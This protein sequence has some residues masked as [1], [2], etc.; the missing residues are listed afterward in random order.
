[1][2]TILQTIIVKKLFIGTRLSFCTLPLESGAYIDGGL[3]FFNDTP[4]PARNE[5]ASMRLYY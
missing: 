4:L 3:P 2:R 5:A 1:M